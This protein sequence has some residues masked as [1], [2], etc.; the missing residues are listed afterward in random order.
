MSK[1]L[2]EV[3]P[4]P[5]NIA[6][7]S[8]VSEGW[9]AIDGGG[10]EKL[11]LQAS[12]PDSRQGASKHFP[13][14]FDATAIEAFLATRLSES[15]KKRCMPVIRKLISGE[16]VTHKAKPGDCFLRDKRVTPA[17]DIDALRVQAAKWLPNS[18]K[19]ALDKGHGWALNHPLKKL[20]EY[21]TYLLGKESKKRKSA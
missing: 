9:D 8:E 7:P 3:P 19:D 2:I 20:A 4:S 16:G 12:V 5:S 11:L 13:S 15:N 17:D 10:F 1:L 18:G 6:M 14:E 21:K